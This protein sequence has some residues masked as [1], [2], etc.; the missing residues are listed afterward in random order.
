MRTASRLTLAIA[1]AACAL[2]AAADDPALATDEQKFSYV[3][4]VRFAQDLLQQGLKVDPAAF[5]LAIEDAMANREPRMT[6]D[7]MKAVV[8]TAQEQA[9]AKASAAGNANKAKGE[10]FRAEY[11]KKD[12][13]KELPD[14]VLYT[15][16]KSG[17]GKSPTA[18][19][20]VEVNYVGKLTDGKEFD[21]SV[22]RGKPAQFPL[23]GI[24]KGWAETLPLMKEGDKWE[25]VIPPELAYGSTGAGATI[26]PEETLVFEIELLKVL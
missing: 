24:I 7:E 1:L 17:T 26:G 19:S 14:G 23:N 20:K 11:R 12:G 5:S 9:Q 6:L 21:S 10:A 22:A 13:V 3:V 15:V 16:L 4:G 2:P 25:V 8:K 18:D